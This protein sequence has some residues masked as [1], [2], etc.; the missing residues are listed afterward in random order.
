MSD[1]TQKVLFAVALVFAVGMG[2][3]Y[4]SMLRGPT[5]EPEPAA[6]TATTTP[7]ATVVAPARPDRPLP[8]RTV[9]RHTEPVTW[10]DEPEPEPDEVVVTG[11]V[12]DE[13]GRPAPQVDVVFL[14]NGRRRRVKS[15]SE[16]SFEFTTKGDQIIV[17]A[18]RKDGQLVARS[19][20]IEV[21][22]S[23]GGQWE[24]DLL[25]ESSR[26]A[27]L[28][29]KVRRHEEGL[30]IRKVIDGS[31]GQDLGLVRGDVIIEVDGEIVAGMGVST[32]TG[33]L[34]GPEGTTQNFTVRHLDGSSEVMEFERRP[35]DARK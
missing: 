26:R 2:L 17:W 30:Y 10:T 8:R 15:N 5:G 4:V 22:G 1:R 27:G 24:V 20:R 23:S 31:P 35:I 11:R 16:G 28:G 25:L 33:R 13:R 21:D 7:L 29:V 12:F 19:S 14:A 18:E 34:T 3:L 32:I 9:P 6:A